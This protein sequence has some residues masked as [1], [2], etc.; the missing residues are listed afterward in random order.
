MNFEHLQARK[1]M[2]S[3]VQRKCCCFYSEKFKDVWKYNRRGQCMLK[4]ML[5]LQL[6][7]YLA[8][9]IILLY[10]YF[11]DVE[12]TYFVFHNKLD[13]F[14]IVVTM[15]LFLA[16]MYFL[17]HSTN[18]S[19]VVDLITYGVLSILLNMFILMRSIDML[20]L[21]KSIKPANVIDDP[22]Q[23]N[24]DLAYTYITYAE[25]V[26]SIL[27]TI[28]ELSIL[29]AVYEDIKDNIFL[30]LGGNT[31]LWL[32]FYNLTL[33]KSVVKLDLIFNCQFWTAFFF[34]VYDF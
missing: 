28:L 17:W 4:L 16:S 20:F 26:T 11:V 34:V 3:V 1:R 31:A 13:F 24:F 9:V 15:W 25:I 7:L 21:S 30:A 18:R 8:T 33:S 2:N 22:S 12:G 23:K 14:Y 6:I 32:N 5:G 29:P 19:I 10:D 27:F